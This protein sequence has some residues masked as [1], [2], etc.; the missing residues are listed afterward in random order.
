M[1]KTLQATEWSRCI[2]T[3]SFKLVGEYS[4]WTKYNFCSSF[5]WLVEYANICWWGF[6]IASCVETGCTWSSLWW[7]WR[8]HIVVF[9]A[10]LHFVTCSSCLEHECPWQVLWEL[11]DPKLIF[12]NVTC[13]A[14]LRVTEEDRSM[15]G[16]SVPWCTFYIHMPRW[17]EEMEVGMTA[18]LVN[19]PGVCTLHH[20]MWRPS[21]KWPELHI[22]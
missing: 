7:Q 10:F 17:V 6:W 1:R 13:S 3:V 22:F 20:Y 15:A 11:S 12:G 5:N 14:S 19:V 8:W 9:V 18:R 21:Q 4:T 2:T 16:L